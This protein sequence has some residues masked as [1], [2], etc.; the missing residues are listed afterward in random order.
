MK[1]E[2]EQLMESRQERERLKAECARRVQDVHELVDPTIDLLRRI[3]G[4][5]E[6]YVCFESLRK[7]VIDDIN[8]LQGSLPP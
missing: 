4:H 6:P 5:L 2:A 7:D 8:R 3:S 1:Y